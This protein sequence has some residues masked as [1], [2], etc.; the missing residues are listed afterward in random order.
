LTPVNK[1]RLF[2]PGL[3]M[4]KRSEDFCRAPKIK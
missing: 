2:G 3:L 1:A 4:A